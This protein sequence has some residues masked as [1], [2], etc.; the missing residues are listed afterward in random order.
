MDSDFWSL[1]T[2]LL[3]DSTFFDAQTRYGFLPR[4][5]AILIRHWNF[6]NRDVWHTFEGRRGFEYT[7]DL[8]HEIYPTSPSIGD[9]WNK[10][11]TFEHLDGDGLVIFLAAGANDLMNGRSLQD[12]TIDLFTM[13]NGIFQKND[14]AV[15]LLATVPMSGDPGEDGSELWPG[16]SAPIFPTGRRLTSIR[17]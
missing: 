9:L 13:L 7:G 12:M 17:L 16:M 5:H 11:C 1:E 14:E 15:V 10:V 3:W 4:L 6:E 2:R 8:R